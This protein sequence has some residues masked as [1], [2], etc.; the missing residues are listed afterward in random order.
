MVKQREL[1]RRF[2]RI[3][4]LG[5]CEAGLFADISFLMGSVCAIKIRDRFMF[6]SRTPARKSSMIVVSPDCFAAGPVL[7]RVGGC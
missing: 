5:F 4:E 6:Q 7:V 2:F 3:S 1:D